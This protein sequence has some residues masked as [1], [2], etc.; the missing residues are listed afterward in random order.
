MYTPLAL[1][2]SAFLHVCVLQDT[3]HFRVLRND[4]LLCCRPTCMM[5][6]WDYDESLPL[7]KVLTW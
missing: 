3:A 5:I 1:S 4:S 6:L 7:V 2:T